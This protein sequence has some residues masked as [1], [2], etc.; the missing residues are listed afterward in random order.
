ML[1]FTLLAGKHMDGSVVDFYQN[2]EITDGIFKRKYSA[3]ILIHNSDW[4]NAARQV[5]AGR[6]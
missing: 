1:G 2:I 5:F 4:K 6:G 3:C